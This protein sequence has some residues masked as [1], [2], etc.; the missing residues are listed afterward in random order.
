MRPTQCPENF[1]E[2]LAT[3]TAT[4]LEIVNG[5]LLRSIILKCVQN[6]KSVALPVPEKI[7]GIRKISVLPR[8]AQSPFSP[9]FLWAFVRMNPLNVPA[10]FEVP[11]F[12]FTRS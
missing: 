7:G 2:S 11:S 5:L 6:L 8:Y 4:F 9:N 12:S 10:K 1:R 3:P